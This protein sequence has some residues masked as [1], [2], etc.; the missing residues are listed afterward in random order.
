MRLAATTTGLLALAAGA[1]LASAADLQLVTEDFGPNPTNASFY[2]YVPDSLSAG[3]PLLVY[4]HWCHG[5]ALN[6]FE[7]KPWR[8]LADQHGFVVIYP[9]SPWTADNCWDVSSAQTLTHDAGGDS[10]G[11]ASMVRWTLDAYAVQLDPDRVFVAGISSGAMMANVLAATYPDL[12]A[13]VSALAGVPYACFAGD[14]HAVWSDD[15]ARGRV[16]HPRDEWAGI[17]RAAFPG[18]DGVRPK[19]QLMHGT[20]DDVLN[21]TNYR[22]EIKMWTAVLGVAEEPTDVT[23]DDPQ[24]GWTRYEYGRYVEGYLGEGVTHDIPDQAADVVRF[25][26]LDCKGEGCF[27]RKT[28]EGWKDCKRRRAR[29]TM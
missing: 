24:E 5:T 18:Y 6:A 15:C 16:V 8:S 23:P 28:L 12:F 19:M 4:P 27:S 17:V 2:L 20:A 13:A 14:G 1:G 10:L 21:V 26:E 3:A 22:E 25:F 7:W 11:I 29:H 9:S